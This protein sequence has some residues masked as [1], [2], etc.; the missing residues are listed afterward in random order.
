MIQK[1]FVAIKPDGVQRGLVGR[2]VQRFEDVGLKVVGMK[3]VHINKEFAA[4]H[5]T[6][7]IAQ[8]RGEH[9]REQLLDFITEG[10]VVAMVLEGV[11][12]I[13]VVRKIVDGTEPKTA[14]PGTIRGDFTHVSYGRGDSTKRAIPNVIHASADSK[15]AE[16]EVGLWFSPEELHDYPTA[17]EKHTHLK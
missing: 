17:H 14:A 8:R 5:Y 11:E 7:D 9:V 4:K 15:D 2:I 12:A 1:T 6:E 3:L 16:H 10:P 13:E